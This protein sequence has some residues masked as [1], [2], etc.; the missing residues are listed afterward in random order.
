M[1]SQTASRLV[2][3]AIGV[4]EEEDVEA[5]D[6]DGREARLGG[7]AEVGGV[8]V[9]SS[10][11]GCVKRG[12]PFGPLPLAVDVVVAD[13]AR[14]PVRIALEACECPA[15]RAIGLALAVDVGR[16]DGVDALARAEERLE[17]VV[18]DR[19][20]EAHVAPAAPGSDRAAAE[21]GHR[22]ER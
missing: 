20:A 19:L 21:L 16:D 4:V 13:G 8:P 3:R 12:K 6:A 15:E 22:R 2:A 11:R 9:R 18:G 5:V 1:P 17:P 10:Q 14:D 7:L